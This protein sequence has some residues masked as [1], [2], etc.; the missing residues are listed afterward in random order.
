MVQH[1]AV[2]TETL[3]DLLHRRAINASTS[4][5]AIEFNTGAALTLAAQLLPATARILLACGGVCLAMSALW[6]VAE[7]R[8][9]ETQI[10]APRASRRS[11]AV[12]LTLRAAATV[13]GV[14]A[15]LTLVFVSIAA[16]LGTWIS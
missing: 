3:S 15:A 6:S 8:I 12:W 5:L 2:Q 16:S 7:A 10:A 9:A 1:P 4:R 13:T 14:A 11:P